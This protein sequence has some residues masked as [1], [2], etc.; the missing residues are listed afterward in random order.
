MTASVPMLRPST[1]ASAWFPYHVAVF[2]CV[3]WQ[4]YARLAS[5][6]LEETQIAEN[7]FN[8]RSEE[9]GGTQLWQQEMAALPASHPTRLWRRQAP[10]VGVG[11]RRSYR[12]VTARRPHAPLGDRRRC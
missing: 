8:R 12:A 7:K 9:L 11:L 10:A 5:P 4:I 3:A 2:I 6:I 1:F